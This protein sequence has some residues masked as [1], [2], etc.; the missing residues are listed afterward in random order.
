M[1]LLHWQT[2]NRRKPRRTAGAAGEDAKALGVALDRVEQQRRRHVL[3]YVELADRAEL[4]V[5]VRALHLPQLAQLVD[6][7]QPGSQ[8]EGV[9]A[10]SWTIIGF[11][12]RCDSSFRCWRFS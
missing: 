6:F 5:P 1:S 2:Q 10:H 8:I 12:H 4:Q 11:V 9:P 3:L 7:G